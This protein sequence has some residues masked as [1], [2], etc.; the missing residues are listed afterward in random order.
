MRTMLSTVAFLLALTT[1]QGSGQLNAV[2]PATP[3]ILGVWRFV[4]TAPPGFVRTGTEVARLT[5]NLQGERLRALVVTG[6]HRYTVGAQYAT[7]RRE[8]LLTVPASAGKVRLQAT[9]GAGTAGAG[10]MLGLWSDTHGDD[11]GFVLLRVPPPR[12][13]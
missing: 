9:L 6:K 13:R 2:H 3:P 1:S 5:L 11:G 8:L 10:R 12:H 7:A 4:G